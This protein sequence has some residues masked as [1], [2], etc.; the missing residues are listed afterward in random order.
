MKNPLEVDITQIAT[1]IDFTELC[2]DVLYTIEY[3][4]LED[5]VKICC[6]NRKYKLDD[7]NNC[8]NS[9]R[10]VFDAKVPCEEPT[11]DFSDVWIGERILSARL[12]DGE[13]NAKI[14]I[15]EVESHNIKI[16]FKSNKNEQKIVLRY[17]EE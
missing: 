8:Y 11:D 4:S 12:E 15:I 6:E 16:I 17:L 10:V 1:A 9:I 3:S 14:F 5:Y 2:K 13:E 7:L